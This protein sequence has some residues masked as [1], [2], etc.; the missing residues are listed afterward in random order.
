MADDGGT[1]RAHYGRVLLKLSGEAFAPADTESGINTDATALIA[2]QL[3]RG[4]RP[5]RPDGGGRRGRQHLARP[6]G[7]RHRPQSGRLHGHAGHGHERPGPA[8]CA[9]EDPRHH[10]GADRDLDDPARRAVHAAARASPPREGAGGHLR[11]RPGGAVLLDRHVR[12]P[13]GARD[14]GRRAAQGHEG[15]RRLHRRPAS[16]I[17]PP[18][19]STS[20]STSTC[21]RRATRSWTPPRS[22]CAWRTSCPII[23]FNLREE[24]NIRRVVNGRADRHARPLKEP[25]DDRFQPQGCLP[26]DGAGRHAPEG[27]AVRDPHRASDPR[28]C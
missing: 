17:R 25:D 16:S 28:A 4:R 10:P 7:A 8:G 11:G 19:A 1:P 9:R 15:R 24:G 13:A 20:S 14:R 12:R 27:R 3:G 22:R 21:S 2:R 5:R 18:S 6:A 26:Q 23:V